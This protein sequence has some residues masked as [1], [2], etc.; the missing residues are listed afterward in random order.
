MR[1]P[2]DPPRIEEIIAVMRQA[3]EGIHGARIRGLIV[4]LWRAGLRMNEALML[5]ETDLEPRRAAIL[6]RCGKGGKRREVGMDDWGWEHLEPWSRYR[7]ELP[8]GPYFC[9]VEGRTRGRTWSQTGARDELR[10]LGAA[11]GVRRRFAPHH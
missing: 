8:V 9:V 11:A 2:A 5:S 10:R 7:L 1:S 4:V 3:G 6:V